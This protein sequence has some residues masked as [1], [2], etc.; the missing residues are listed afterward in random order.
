[1]AT[2]TRTVY[3]KGFSESIGDFVSVVTTADGDAAFLTIVSSAFL[4]LDGGTD[5]DIFEGWYARIADSGSTANEESQR[6][7]AYIPDPDAATVRVASPFSVTIESGITIELHRYNPVDKHNVLGQALNQLSRDLALPVRDESIIIDNL[8]TNSDFETFSTANVPDGWT[9]VGSPTVTE[10]NTIVRHGTSSVKVVAGGAVGRLTQAPQVNV[11]EMTAEDAEHDRWVY[12]TAANTARLGID[13]GSSIVFS[14]YHTGQDQWEYLELESAIPPAATQ[15]KAIC[16]VAA[17]GTGYFD[18]GHLSV[19][20]IYDYALPSS[21]VGDPSSI[22]MQVNE[23]HP[24]GPYYP[25]PDG[26]RPV[27]GMI[28]RVRGKGVLSVPTTDSG[29][30]EI[31]EPQLQLLYAYA[32]MLLWRMLASPARSAGQDRGSL[33]DAAKGAAA[34]VAVLRAQ[35][36]MVTPRTGAQ[37]HRLNWVVQGDGSDRKIVFTQP[38]GS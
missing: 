20:A 25:I 12:A 5:D 38:R 23:D 29:T 21:L 32:E 36:G 28:L 26:G 31:G 37:R 35:K 16:E 1:M 9:I 15:I 18:I 13:F 6:I 14:S 2:S 8:L 10:E 24:E 19:D 27:E 4:G 33:L 3:S 11:D 34:Q 7:A 22:E 17:N 30:T